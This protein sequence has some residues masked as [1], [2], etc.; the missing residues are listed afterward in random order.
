MVRR[1]VA[2]GSA[3]A[4]SSPSS[5]TGGRVPEDGIKASRH[6]GIEGKKK[7]LGIRHWAVKKPTDWN[8]EVRG[9]RSGGIAPVEGSAMT[10]RLCDPIAT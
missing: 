3:D 10:V 6:H 5:P 9:R 7:A 1:A 2:E 4:T 8:P